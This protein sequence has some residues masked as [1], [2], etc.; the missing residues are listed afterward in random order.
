MQ[1]MVL[2]TLPVLLLLMFIYERLYGT[3]S[4]PEV[5]S[6]YL[7][8]VAM[9]VA[10]FVTVYVGF[11]LWDSLFS[12]NSL[13]LLE[14][15]SLVAQVILGFTLISFV[16]Y[17]QHRLKHRFDWL[18]RYFH[19]V[20]HSPRRVEILT[21]FYRSPQ[22]IL[23]NMILM[24]AI[25]YLGLGVSE[26]AGA[27]IVFLM[28][29]ADLFYHWN[30]STPVWLGYFIQRPEAH[31]MHHLTGVHAFNYGDIPLW[32]IL[33][34]TFRNPQYFKGTCGFSGVQENRLF[35]LSAGTVTESHRLKKH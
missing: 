32:D 14:S 24:S 26:V 35:A 12:R 28:G 31:C 25:L 13:A 19:Q 2:Y 23:V 27:W 18:W 7:R 20:H 11:F 6:W 30:I 3:R 10:Q 15:L 34:G 16:S 33:F 29:I 8:S 22:E 21:S 17:W 5:R 9:I 4:W 1:R